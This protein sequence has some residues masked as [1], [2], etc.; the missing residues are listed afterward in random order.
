MAYT[1]AKGKVREV[2]TGVF[3]VMARTM[4]DIFF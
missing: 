1:Q 3:D 2:F 4:Y